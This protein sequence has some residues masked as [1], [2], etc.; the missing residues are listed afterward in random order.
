MKTGNHFISTFFTFFFLLFSCG[1]SLVTQERFRKFPPYPEPLADLK[2][3]DVESASLSNGLAISVIHKDNFPVINL[4]LII[5]TGESSSP[6]ELPGT[7]TFTAKMLSRGALNLSSSEIEE[8]IESI[9]GNF[10]DR[11]SVV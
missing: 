4:R 9:G 6:E 5:F 3:P 11:K 8:K 10:T 1:T 2:L 7:A